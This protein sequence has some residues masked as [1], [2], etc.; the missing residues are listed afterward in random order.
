MSSHEGPPYTWGYLQRQSASFSTSTW[1]VPPASIEATDTL[2]A[3]LSWHPRHGGSGC[4]AEKPEDELDEEALD[5]AEELEEL[6]VLLDEVEL[7]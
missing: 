5:D 6:L 7:G 2:A 3:H 1:Q 4:A